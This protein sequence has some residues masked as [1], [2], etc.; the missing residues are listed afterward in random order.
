M[1][2]IQSCDETNIDKDIIANATSR[3]I[4]THATFSITVS[5]YDISDKDWI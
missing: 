1:Y 2:W 4:L 3:A 5:V